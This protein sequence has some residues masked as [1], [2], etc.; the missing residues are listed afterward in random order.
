MLLDLLLLPYRLA[1]L[2]ALGCLASSPMDRQPGES[3]WDHW[4]RTQYDP[5]PDWMQ[6]R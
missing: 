6:G 1:G 2:A 5:R 3:A 4:R